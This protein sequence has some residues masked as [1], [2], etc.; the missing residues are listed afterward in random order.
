MELFPVFFFWGGAL[1]SPNKK[2][3]NF[4]EYT[5]R[6]YERSLILIKMCLTLLPTELLG[7]GKEVIESKNEDENEENTDGPV[8]VSQN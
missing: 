6:Y 5:S 7:M 1:T 3:K 4:T 8:R 2:D